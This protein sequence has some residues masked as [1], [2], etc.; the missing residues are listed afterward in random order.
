MSTKREAR[1]D[2]KTGAVQPVKHFRAVKKESYVDKL[3]SL[4][5]IRSKKT[6]RKK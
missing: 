2:S 3:R 5:D 6:S 1:S 4:I